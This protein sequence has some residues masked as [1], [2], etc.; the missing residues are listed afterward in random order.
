MSEQTSV[1]LE[2]RS[3]IQ[4]ALDYTNRSI[5][6]GS[7]SRAFQELMYGLDMMPGQGASLPKNTDTQGL[8]FFTRPTMNLSYDNLALDRRL[9]PLMTDDVATYPFMVRSLLD[10][11][12]SKSRRS[13]FVDSDNVFMPILSNTL[14]SMSGWPDVVGDVYTASEGAQKES[15]A[16]FDGSSHNRQAWDAN[17]T[18]KNVQGDPITLLILTWIIY[19]TGV[20][21]GDLLPYSQMMFQNRIDYQTGIYR[22]GLS[23]DGRYVTKIARTI[24]FPYAISLGAAFNYQADQFLNSENDTISVPFKCIGAEYQDPILVLEFNHA[25][26]MVNPS[27]R[28]GSGRVVKLDRLEHGLFRRLA[29]PKIDEE[30]LELQWW[31]PKDVYDVVTTEFDE[32][33]KNMTATQKTQEA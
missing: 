5:G 9:S 15:W 4:E 18:F 24:G 29:Y 16:M 13:P 1:D 23:S 3:V 21:Q 27:M 19:G 28:A 33:G 2:K 32:A 14:L 8:V 6:N 17:M 10:P 25:M 7:Q 30:T 11:F 31:V 26:N 12:A 20:Y 22:L